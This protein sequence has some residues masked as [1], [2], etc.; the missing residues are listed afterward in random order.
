[1]LQMQT[2]KHGPDLRGGGAFVN[3]AKFITRNWR[4]SISVMLMLAVTSY[5]VN[6]AVA[7]SIPLTAGKMADLLI[8]LITVI[9][10]YLI[11]YYFVTKLMLAEGMTD[12]GLTAKGMFSFLSAGALILAGGIYCAVL[13]TLQGINVFVRIILVVPAAIVLIRCLLAPCFVVANQSAPID[14]LKASWSVTKGYGWPIFISLALL[15]V[16]VKLIAGSSALFVGT[17][18]LGGQVLTQLGDSASNV[19]SFCFFV[20]IYA[21]LVA[22][23]SKPSVQQQSV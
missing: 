11:G 1:M 5:G 15:G 17:E 19:V 8:S 14:S 22:S 12:Q 2:A 13:S 6:L 23:T 18:K 20:G 21:V 3:L 9:P 7:S 4:L 10:T 16:L